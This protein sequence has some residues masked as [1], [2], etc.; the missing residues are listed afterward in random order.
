[1]KLGPSVRSICCATLALAAAV[2]AAGCAAVGRPGEAS[3]YLIVDSLQAASGA[4]P[5][6]FSD[7]LASDVLTNVGGAPTILEDQVLPC[8]RLKPGGEFGLSR[9]PPD[10]TR[11]GDRGRQP[12]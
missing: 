8:R 11:D 9:L 5:G 3:A 6:T 1:M 12:R 7:S 10:G 4:K 2:V